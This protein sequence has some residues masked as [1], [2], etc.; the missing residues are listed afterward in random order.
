MAECSEIEAGGE[1][2]TIKDATARNGIAANA[3]A[4]E[5][6]VAKIPSNAS[7]SNKMITQ[8]DIKNYQTENINFIQ[9]PGL[10]MSFRDNYEYAHRAYRQGNT[11]FIQISLIYRGIYT[12]ETGWKQIF[13]KPTNIIKQGESVVWPYYMQSVR[14]FITGFQASVLSGN[15]VILENGKNYNSALDMWIA[16]PIVS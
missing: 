5:E 1:V 10:T 13:T 7:S 15:M 14:D 4:I 8:A 3:A 12:G 11:L 16:M 2:R 6:I 9:Q